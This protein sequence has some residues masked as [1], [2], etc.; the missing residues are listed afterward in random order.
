MYLAEKIGSVVVFLLSI[1][2]GVAGFSFNFW[3]EY[4]PGAGLW[5]ALIAGGWFII[6][7]IWFIEANTLKG[8]GKGFAGSKK[9]LMN[10]VVVF[11]AFGV[12]VAILGFLGFILSTM[13]FVMFILAYQE[14]YKPVKSFII[15]AFIS[16]GLFLMFE[17]WLSVQ[18][19]HGF[20]EI[21]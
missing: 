2:I 14:K 12:Y 6:S 9:N 10:I 21:I 18:L 11:G 19:P 15:S 8:S 17:V 1:A 4:G 20:L 7:I 5:P 3:E 13:A 16:V